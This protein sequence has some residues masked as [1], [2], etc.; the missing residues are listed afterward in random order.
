METTQLPFVFN[1]S[2]KYEFDNNPLHNVKT[3][4]CHTK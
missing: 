4:Q 1:D 3:I 2:I